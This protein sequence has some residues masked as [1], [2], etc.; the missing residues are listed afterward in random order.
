MQDT[1]RARGIWGPGAGMGP[2]GASLPPGAPPKHGTT[3]T[4]GGSREGRG[5]AGGFWGLGDRGGCGWHWVLGDRSGCGWHWGPRGSRWRWGGSGGVGSGVCSRRGAGAGS[6][7]PACASPPLTRSGRTRPGPSSTGD[8]AGTEGRWGVA[9]GA[10][11]PSPHWGHRAG[12]GRAAGGCPLSP[13]RALR[14][15]G[16]LPGDLGHKEGTVVTA[17][18]TVAGFWVQGPRSHVGGTFWG[19]WPWEWDRGC[20]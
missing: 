10:R 16:A 6:G 17:G 19:S 13:H 9:L 1:G 15:V 8:P 7:T 12:W 5:R 3:F 4:A 14:G 20:V 2:W 18:D 11:C